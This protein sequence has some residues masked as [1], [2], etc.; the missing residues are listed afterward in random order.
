MDTVIHK[1]E[2]KKNVYEMIVYSTI[3]ILKRFIFLISELRQPIVSLSDY[4]VI[5][6]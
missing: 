4:K 6:K 1:N 3:K 5:Y 2:K